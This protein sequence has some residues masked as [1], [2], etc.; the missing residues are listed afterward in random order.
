MED[1]LVTYIPKRNHAVAS[2]AIIV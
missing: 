1:G 2:T